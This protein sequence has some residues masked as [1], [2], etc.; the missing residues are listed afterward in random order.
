MEEDM[1]PTLGSMALHPRPSLPHTD[2]A[3][4]ERVVLVPCLSSYEI[5]PCSTCCD[6]CFYVALRYTILCH[7]IASWSYRVLQS[8]CSQMHTVCCTLSHIDATPFRS[9]PPLRSS[10]KIGGGMKCRQSPAIS[11]GL[12]AARS[13]FWRR[14]LPLAALPPAPP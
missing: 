2:C 11:A 5:T 3:K 9:A 7:A 10:S 6:Y 4:S 12:C 14:V 13:V 8:M 1:M